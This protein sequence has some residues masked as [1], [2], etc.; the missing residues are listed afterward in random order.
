MGENVIREIESE[1]DVREWSPEAF[2]NFFV[3]GYLE[4]AGSEPTIV[5]TSKNQILYRVHN[6]L[7]LELAVKMPETM[8][9]ILHEAFHEGVS[10]AMD[11]KGKIVRLTCMGHGDPYCEHRCDWHASSQ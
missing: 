7:F 10:K 2:T 4:E 8:C 6:C 11:G 5:E 9:D 3:K 1:H